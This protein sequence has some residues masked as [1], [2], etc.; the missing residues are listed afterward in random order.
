MTN[1]ESSLNDEARKQQL[2]PKQR[3]VI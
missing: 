3:F 2:L 1:D